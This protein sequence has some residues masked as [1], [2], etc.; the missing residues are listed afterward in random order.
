[1][2][3]TIRSLRQERGLTQRQ[4]ADYLRIDRSTY[5]YYESGHSKLS[6][7]ILVKLAHFYKVSYAT[8]IGR[9]EPVLAE[10]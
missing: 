8:L 3:E 10:S 4:V 5:A 7:D 1:M 9:P 6:I 2:H